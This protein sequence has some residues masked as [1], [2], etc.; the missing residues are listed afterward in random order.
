[1]NYREHG[2]K[3]LSLAITIKFQATVDRTLYL[4]IVYPIAMYIQ[5]IGN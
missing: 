4:D 2:N 1:M 5:I 3:H